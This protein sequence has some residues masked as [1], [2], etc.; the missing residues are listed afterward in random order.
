VTIVVDEWIACG[1]G[2][3]SFR[4]GILWWGCERVGTVVCGGV[5]W[6]KEELLSR[7]ACTFQRE[8]KRS[9]RE[10]DKSKE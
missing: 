8:A 6:V 9:V 2:K 3:V 1:E 4:K 10:A 7:E 5:V